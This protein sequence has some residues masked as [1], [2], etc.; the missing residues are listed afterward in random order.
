MWLYDDML[1]ITV[2]A[3]TKMSLMFASVDGI[4]MINRSVAGVHLK[5]SGMLLSCFMFMKNIMEEI[6]PKVTCYINTQQNY[7]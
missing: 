4:L 3:L 2:F 1:K 6:R 5:L 7:A